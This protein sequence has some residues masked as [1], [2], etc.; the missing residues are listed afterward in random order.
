MEKKLIYLLL[1]IGKLITDEVRGSLSQYGLHFGQAR[2]LLT[3]LNFEE[4]NQKEVSEG[5]HIKPATVTNLIKK[6]ESSGLVK[7]VRSDKD[8]RVINVTLTT[9]GMEAAKIVKREMDKIDSRITNALVK[10]E[11]K[12]IV[13][14]LLKIR[15]ILGGIEPK[16]LKE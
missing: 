2:I 9:K 3:L 11:L 8:D 13:T 6:L 15:D 14:P 4:L 10:D 16:L 12:T 1:H 7:R 5:L